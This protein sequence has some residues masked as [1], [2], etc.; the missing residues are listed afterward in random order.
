MLADIDIHEFEKQWEAMLEECGVRE[1]KWVRDLNAKK[2]S[3]ATAYIRGRFYAGLRTSSRCESLDAKLG[4]VRES[5]K[6]SVQVNIIGCNHTSNGDVFIVEKYRKSGLTW[7]VLYDGQGQKFGCSCMRME[8]FGL[9]CIHILA[10]VVRLNLCA[11]SDS[12]V[13]K[14]W[15]KTA[16]SEAGHWSIVNEVVDKGILYKRRVAAFVHLCTR[17]EK[18]ACLDE[19]DFKVYAERIVKDTSMLESKYGVGRESSGAS[20]VGGEFNGINDPV[21]LRTKG[22]GHAN[23]S[24]TMTGKKRRKCSNCGHLGHWRT[25]CTSAPASFA[26]DIE[27]DRADTTGHVKLSTTKDELSKS[28]VRLDDP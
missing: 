22:I 25:R 16:K 26:M 8:S 11:I 23:M 6:R 5:L 7:Q 19:H 14:R 27:M 1:V 24:L 18:F 4:R 21:R 3:W 12:L 28:F 20:H 2:Y 9:P 13:L 10:V 17:L 15:S